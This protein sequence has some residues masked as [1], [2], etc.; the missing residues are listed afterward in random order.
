MKELSNMWD[1]VLDWGDDFPV[2]SSILIAIGVLVLVIAGFMLSWQM[3]IL[4]IVAAF[5]TGAATAIV[6]TLRGL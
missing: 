4:L 1:A 6:M 5:I 2:F 3:M